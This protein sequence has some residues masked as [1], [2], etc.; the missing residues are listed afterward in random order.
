[1]EAKLKAFP[2]APQPVIQ[3]SIED[4]VA[5]ILEFTRSETN[6][7]PRFEI[8][9]TGNPIVYNVGRGTLPYLI[10]TS[11][12]VRTEGGVTVV[13]TGFNAF[14]NAPFPPAETVWHPGSAF[15]SVAETKP[16]AEKAIPAETKKKSD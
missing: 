4:M 10:N 3:R 12:P 14:D 15:N 16:S 11:A 13:G 2:A 5:E 7:R 1:L 6:K 8:L 9:Q